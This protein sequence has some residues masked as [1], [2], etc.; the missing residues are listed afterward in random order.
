MLAAAK[1]LHEECWRDAPLF[2]PSCVSINEI[3][4]FNMLIDKFDKLQFQQCYIKSS[5][6]DRAK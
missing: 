5:K 3:Y 1:T 4:F 2:I 6:Y